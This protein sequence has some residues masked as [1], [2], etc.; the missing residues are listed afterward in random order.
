MII[1]D[2]IVIRMGLQ[3]LLIDAGRGYAVVGVFAD[4][5]EAL[6][7]IIHSEADVVIT[8]IRMAEME[9]VELIKIVRE[10]NIEIPFIILSGYNDFEY[11]RTVF[12]YGASDYL[13]KPVVQS[14]LFRCLDKIALAKGIQV[15]H[16]E[17][18]SADSR[19]VDKLKEIIRSEYAHE[20]KLEDLSQ[21]VFL[22]PKYIS[23]MFR[24]E[25]GLSLT[26]YMVYIR[27]EKA[28]QLMKENPDLKVYEVAN[29]VGYQDSVYF[30]KI[31]KKLIG[32]TPFEY[33]NKSGQ[34]L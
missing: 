14:E 15:N 5:K 30:N 28:K 2:E 21:R 1:D 19:V 29:L 25:T 4:G 9:G 26:N 27:M 32:C 16:Q 18:V 12:R 17:I 34:R 22:N 31:F 24:L 3:K 10:M 11:A 23:R 8:D 20:L 33:K 13:L 6:K 7:A